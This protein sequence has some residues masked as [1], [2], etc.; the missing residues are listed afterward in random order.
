MGTGWQTAYAAIRMVVEIAKE[1]SDMCSPLKMVIGAM[2]ALMKNCDVSVFCSQTGCL[3]IF[4]LFPTQQTPDN[5][6]GLEEIKQRVQLLYSVLASPVSDD[7]YAEKGR[8][9]ELRRFVFE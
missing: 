2:S 7:D 4:C 3:L 6:E 9:V 5:A 8:R 1:T